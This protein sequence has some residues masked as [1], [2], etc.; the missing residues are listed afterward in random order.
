MQLEIVPG[1][2]AVWG[3]GLAGGLRPIQ[4]KQ[5]VVGEVDG[6]D[7]FELMERIERAIARIERATSE[8][9]ALQERL[10]RT[11]VV[12]APNPEEAA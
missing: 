4:K 10:E 3:W 11:L 5:L 7:N 8:L 1:W 2:R 9:G 6:V 12:L